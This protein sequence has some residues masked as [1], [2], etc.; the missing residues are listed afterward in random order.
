MPEEAPEMTIFTARASALLLVLDG[1]ALDEV[2]DHADHLARAAG[3]A[4]RG[5]VLAVDDEGGHALDV[6]GVERLLGRIDLRLDLFRM[7]QLEKARAV[8]AVRGDPVGDVLLFVELLAVE[9]M[10]V[11]E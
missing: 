6:V 1:G 10:V 11:V 5:E 9:M 8:D 3:K 2:F 7:P 4:R